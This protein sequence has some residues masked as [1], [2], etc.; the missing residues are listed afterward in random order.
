MWGEALI[1][2]GIGD[3]SKWMLGKGW[4][5]PPPINSGKKVE[6]DHKA[7][8]MIPVIDCE[9]VEAGPKANV[10]SFGISFDAAEGRSSWCSG[11]GGCVGNGG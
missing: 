6:H 10:N 5:L 1:G 11:V 7:L 9:S 3:G 2:K 4:V 8:E